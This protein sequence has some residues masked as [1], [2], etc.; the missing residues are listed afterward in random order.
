MQI[1]NHHS[2]PL[3]RQDSNQQVTS[4][5][6]GPQHSN[7]EKVSATD[8]L[9]EKLAQHI[10]GMTN[11]DELRKLD[12]KDFTPQKV[13]NRVT[14][15]VAMGLEQA[16]RS[17]K[18]EVEVENLRLAAAS[19]IQKGIAEAR[20]I[21]DNMNLLT[22]D[23]SA[24]IDETLKLTMQGLEGLIPG[25]APQASSANSTSMLAAERYQS[26]ESLS[27]K[28]KTQ[29]GDMVTILFNKESDYQSSMGGYSDD[30]GSAVSFSVDRSESSDYR[31]SVE[32]D[33]DADEIDALQNLIK[34]VNEIAGEFFDGDVQAAFEQA[35]EFK[36][37]KTELASMNLRL[38][39]SESY[40]AVSAY[41][42]VQNQD[43]Q[44]NGGRKLGHMINGLADQASNPALSF[45]E[46]PFE[47]A[48][49]LLSGLVSEDHRFKKSEDDARSIL[50]DHLNNMR[51]IIDTIEAATDKAKSETI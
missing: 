14:D 22:D 29:D 11:A 4:L 49:E 6:S 3:N 48:K 9:L 31:F 39:R 28:V 36:M 32:G 27:L 8:K 26:A 13:A 2:N 33:L 7:D 41:Q 44:A 37:D 34:D 35:S 5:R 18:S 42:Q 23:I 10:P 17:G 38:T 1:T 12:A 21:L 25:A 19:G 15:F 16:R 43:T 46:S 40:S 50:E 30:S 20:D 24:D 45:V 51:N 47:L